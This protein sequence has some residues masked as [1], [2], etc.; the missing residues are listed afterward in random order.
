MT[1]TLTATTIASG[2]GFLEGPRFRDGVIYAADHYRKLVYRIDLETGATENLCF[3]ANQP[4]GLAFR[5]DGMLRIVSMLDRR[6]LRL[7]AGELVEEADLSAVAPFPTN[8]MTMDRQGRLYIGAFG[9]V[10]G[11]DRSLHR[12]PIT[13]VD[14]D[15][16]VA[17]MSMDLTS[18]NGL[19][20][21]R[22][23]TTLYVADTFG[24][25]LAIFD[26]LADGGLQLRGF[27][28]FGPVAYEN[29]VDAA[30]SDDF[31]PDGIDIDSV[32][33]IWVANA[34]TASVGIY[35]PETQLGAEVPI[36]GL[37]ANVYAVAIAPDGRVF[38]CVAPPMMT[39]DAENEFPS[40]LVELRWTDGSANHT[41]LNWQHRP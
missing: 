33:R 30:A 35:D 28:R 7:D 38:A 17:V 37:N 41:D 26:V 11:G 5:S 8:D 13:R 40:R 12:T 18:P 2:F 3:V 4:S 9:H 29:L 16:T 10:P 23:Q 22:E 31:F 14:P 19:V 15:G 36:E 6:L 20:F 34:H 24:C 21:D 1:V 39:W 27:H 32:G 25:R